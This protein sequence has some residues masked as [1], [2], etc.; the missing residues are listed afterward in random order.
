[1]VTCSHAGG[2]Q[3]ADVEAGSRRHLPDQLIHPLTR[4]A[5]TLVPPLPEHHSPDLLKDP[6]QR[7]GRRLD[8][9]VHVW[10]GG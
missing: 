8:K 1:M 5:A 10:L 9:P 4:R 2:R 7:I 6:I 3:A